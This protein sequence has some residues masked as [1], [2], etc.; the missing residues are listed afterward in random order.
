MTQKSPC[1]SVPLTWGWA[2]I[3]RGLVQAKTVTDACGVWINYKDKLGLIRHLGAVWTVV[4]PSR[5]TTVT[6]ILLFIFI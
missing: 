5:H 2:V 6:E 3:P 1:N 4:C